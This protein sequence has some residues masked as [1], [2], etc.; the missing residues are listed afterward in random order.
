MHVRGRI[1]AFVLVCAVVG[2]G[3]A[4]VAASGDP[5]ATGS[6]S[7]S[8]LPPGVM[9]AQ[10]ACAQVVNGEPR[11]FFTGIRQVRL[12]LTTYAKGEPIASE[13]DISTGMPP[14]TTVW[15]VEV[16]AKAVNWD[17]STPA[18]VAVRP[19]TDFAVVMNARTGLVSD[20]GE[21]DCWP[22]PLGQAGPVVSLPARC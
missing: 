22:L 16:R 21:C 11:G 8:A 20:Q 18:G 17:H 4:A 2:C 12:V 3:Q 5:R 1:S 10:R 9:S 19:A 14:G 15:V 13:G 6:V 7:A